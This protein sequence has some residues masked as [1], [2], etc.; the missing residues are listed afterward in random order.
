MARN[1]KTE[2]EITAD[3]KSARSEIGRLEQ[4]FT[5]SMQELGKS[6]KEIA[7]FRKLG[8]NAEENKAAIDK[9]DDATKQLVQNY[10]RLSGTAADKDFLGLKSHGK[11]QSEIDRTRAAY[12]RLK[13][14]GTL[15]KRELAQAS[16]IAE[17]RV[18]AL[19]AQMSAGTTGGFVAGLDRAK[20]AILGVV[21][22]AK[23]LYSSFKFIVSSADE[24][25]KTADK[26]GLTTDALQALRVAANDAGVKAGGL[27]SS[28]ERF[29]RQIGEAAQ[30]SG[31][32]KGQLDKLGISVVGTNGMIRTTESVLYDYA[33]AIQAAANPQ[34]RLRLAVAAFGKS[35]ASMVNMLKGGGAALQQY[36]A[37]AKQAGHVI[38]EYLIRRAEKLNSDWDRFTN[39]LGSGFK[40][41]V[42]SA[43]R[44]FTGGLTEMEQKIESATKSLQTQE[45]FLKEYRQRMEE[46]ANTRPPDW[47]AEMER[48]ANAMRSTE[49]EAARLR[50]QLDELYGE[51]GFRGTER[52][53]RGMDALRA[54]ISET[55]GET[56]TLYAETKKLFA[57]PEYDPFSQAETEAQRLVVAWQLVGEAAAAARRGDDDAADKIEQ[58]AGALNKLQEGGAASAFELQ[59]LKDTLGGMINEVESVK[60]L[61]MDDIIDLGEAGTDQF[62]ARVNQAI[63]AAA[64]GDPAQLPVTVDVGSMDEMR[65]AINQ[66]FR[67]ASV[68][69]KV[70]PDLSA[71]PKSITVPVNAGNVSDSTADAKTGG[72][73]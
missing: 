69:I 61:T 63:E 73:P 6:K 55:T 25:G 9:L 49:R 67:D 38:D 30:G 5:S 26:I 44:V 53:V 39:K 28:M 45:R 60:P 14:S 2:I 42:L 20:F 65:D 29:A 62:A 68:M 8:R 70:V 50:G 22:S 10:A 13:K 19:N 46:L 23:G 7:E 18:R 24:V 40:G 4:A 51:A 17:Q 54:S 36:I 58:A 31:T 52:A 59:Q 43:S 1:L 27:E 21:A 37:E 66:H 47:E 32:L 48:T 33:D 35:G 16:A 11:L 15:T 72:R 57:Q 71:I 56:K 34:E 64:A 41:A 3:T 12:E